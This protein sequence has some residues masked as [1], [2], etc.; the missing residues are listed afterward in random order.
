[1]A[2]TEVSSPVKKPI[3]TVQTAAPASVQTPVSSK[4][5]VA[6]KTPVTANAPAAAAQTA[7]TASPS[8]TVQPSVPAAADRSAPTQVVYKDPN[9][10]SAM[11]YI[12]NGKTYQDRAGTQR[13]A[14]GSVVPTPNGTYRLNADGSS[15]L[16]TEPANPGVSVDGM[17]KLIEQSSQAEIDQN[18]ASIDYATQ[19]GVNDL[20]R[21]L[22]DAQ[23]GYQSQRDQISID[24]RQGMDNSALYSELRGDRGGI[25]KAQYDSIQNTAAQNR[26]TV[27]KEQQKLATD[28]QRQIADLRA[29]GEFQKADAVL[30]SAQSKLSALVD[31]EQ[32]AANY[33]LSTQQL[34]QSIEEWRASA[35][36]KLSNGTPTYSAQ[37]DALERASARAKTAISMGYVPD[38]EGLSALGITSQQA[39]EYIA[40]QKAAAKKRT[41]SSGTSSSSSSSSRSSSSKPTLTAAQTLSA[42]KSGVRTQSVLD[43]YKYYYG[44]DYSGTDAS[45]DDNS[46]LGTNAT[47]LLADWKANS[48]FDIY[49]A[50]WTYL[51][52]GYITESEYNRLMVET[53]NE[54]DAILKGE[55]P[56]RPTA[57]KKM[58]VSAF[59]DVRVMVKKW[60]SKNTQAGNGMARAI[61]TENQDQM[62]DE[63]FEEIMDILNNGGK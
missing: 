35:T 46:K 61:A 14:A 50:A 5:P 41:S 20:N 27:A 26:I 37:Q 4:T 57:T 29:Q 38:A 19:K 2:D 36:G 28:T 63:Q 33:N 32:W 60:I 34:Q 55:V 6:A 51:K 44:E 62:S 40:L 13:I 58:D 48:D 23:E 8:Q 30:K 10:K 21:A 59:N 45:T 11:G 25:G 1:M 54:S 52:Q 17:K 49:K 22:E 31:L 9:G 18:N 47:R 15:S 7:Q 56:N 43:A 42:L 39:K 12:V 24:E 3:N 16:Y 53:G